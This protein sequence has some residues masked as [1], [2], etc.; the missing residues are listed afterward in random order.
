MITR[1]IG[2]MLS[3][4]GIYV[5]AGFHGITLVEVDGAGRCWSLEPHKFAPQNELPPEGWS[6][7]GVGMILGPLAR[8]AAPVRHTVPGEQRIIPSP[9]TGEPPWPNSSIST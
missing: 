2:I 6:P 9:Q 5:I 3:A 8:P 4:P 1:S 7:A